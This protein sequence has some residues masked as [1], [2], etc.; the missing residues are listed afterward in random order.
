MPIQL[1]PLPTLKPN[2]NPLIKGFL[3]RVLMSCAKRSDS[4]L[5]L[6]TSYDTP[7]AAA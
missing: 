2:L 5:E 1:T 6:V 3:N 7:V 4:A